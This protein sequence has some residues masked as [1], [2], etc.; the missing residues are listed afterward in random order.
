M[1]K[2]INA[3]AEMLELFVQALA[4]A[5]VILTKLLF[6]PAIVAVLIFAA[7][8]ICGRVADV[9]AEVLTEAK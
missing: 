4:V 7:V 9:P 1:K 3:I 8:W 5:V 2:Q 6:W